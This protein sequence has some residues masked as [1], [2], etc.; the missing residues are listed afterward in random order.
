MAIPSRQLRFEPGVDIAVADVLVD[1]PAPPARIPEV[2]GGASGF[3]GL[4]GLP[5]GMSGMAGMQVLVLV[6][7]T[8]G[9][10]TKLGVAFGRR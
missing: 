10:G 1:R 4:R 3:V 5:P 6:S 9:V 8:D 2:I 7:G